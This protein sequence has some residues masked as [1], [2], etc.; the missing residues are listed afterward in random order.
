[1]EENQNGLDS[2]M[3]LLSMLAAAEDLSVK[4][5]KVYSRLLTDMALAQDMEALASRHE[6]RRSALTRL[7][8]GEK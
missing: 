6:Q 4:K 3:Q 8:G 2:E 1:M 7:S 5:A